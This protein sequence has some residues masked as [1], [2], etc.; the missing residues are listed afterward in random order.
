MCIFYGT[1][2]SPILTHTH[3]NTYTYK[4]YT[5]HR[6]LIMSIIHFLIRYIFL[7]YLND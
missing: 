5:Q 3:M 1:S 7:L 2:M 4:T 6:M